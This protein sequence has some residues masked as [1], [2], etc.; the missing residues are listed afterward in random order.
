MAEPVQATVPG[1]LGEEK[2][3]VDSSN[4]THIELKESLDAN[5]VEFNRHAERS[6]KWKVDFLILPILSLTFLMAY[7]AWCPSRASLS[8]WLT[9]SGPKQ[10]GQRE[11]HVFGSRCWPHCSAVL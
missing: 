5:Q 7:M 3:G 1:A 8:S 2:Y 6:L 11:N 4:T 10:S 9:T